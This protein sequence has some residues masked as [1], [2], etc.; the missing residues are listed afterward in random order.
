[1]KVNIRLCDCCCSSVYADFR[2]SVSKVMELR[3]KYMDPLLSTVSSVLSSMHN[4]STSQK[5]QTLS[6]AQPGVNPTTPTADIEKDPYY[7]KGGSVAD[8]E[9]SSVE[10]SDEL[11]DIE[12]MGTINGGD[13]VDYVLEEAPIEL[14]NEYLFALQ[15]HACYWSAAALPHSPLV[16]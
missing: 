11:P 2:D 15:S 13:R 4:T 16:F 14:I 5:A 10:E 6:D 1:M 8:A 12:T 7:D 9:S 3:Q